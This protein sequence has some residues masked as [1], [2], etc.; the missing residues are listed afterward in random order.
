M[1]P[2]GFAATAAEFGGQIIPGD[3]GL[4]DEEN[5]G[6]DHAIIEWFATWK[7]EPPQGRRRQQRLNT[8]PKRIADKRSHGKTPG[9]LAGRD[10]MFRPAI[11]TMNYQLIACQMNHFFR[12]V[13]KKMALVRISRVSSLMISRLINS[14]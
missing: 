4:E 8:F 7:A 5:T 11:P 1:M 13:L 14:L 12:T 3:A 2:A 9:N 6:E 10:G